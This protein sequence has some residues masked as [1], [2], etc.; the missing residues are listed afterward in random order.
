MVQLTSKS[1]HENL[2]TS[3][4]QLRLQGHLS[5]VTVQV[6]YQG[7]VQEFQAHQLMLAASSGYF[8]KILLSQDA[9]QDK[10]LLSNMH[11]NDFSKFLDF[12]Y[13]GKV[14]VVRDKIADVQAAAQ[15]LDCEDLSEVCSEAMSA[16]I[17][18]K[19][20]KK[21][22]EGKGDL[23]GAQKEKGTK[24]KT[25]SFL[26]KRRLSPQSAEK[27]VISKRLKAGKRQGRNLKLRL[28]GRKVLQRR[29]NVKKEA[30]NENKETEENEDG[31]EADGT[32][33]EAQPEKLDQESSLGMP[34]SDVIDWD[35]EADVQSSD[36]EDS[37]L[38]SLEEEE[39]EEEEGEPKEALKRTSK[40][41]FQCNKC[42]RTF[43]Y[44]RSYLKHIR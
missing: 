41:Q 19:P 22:S 44:E 38:L 7:D 4:H 26:L 21:A 40:A 35:C 14:E 42:Q 27:D 8:K 5:D 2:L 34:I 25:K 31:A 28:A 9:T 6:D 18:Q 36:H 1:H 16:G 32:E 13:T 37:L 33:A 29:L 12:I 43:H 24:G 10:V 15:F 17:L 20:T 3:L 39:E 23:H 11:S 30:N